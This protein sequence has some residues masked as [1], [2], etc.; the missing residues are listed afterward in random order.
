MSPITTTQVK[1]VAARP[2]QQELLDLLQRQQQMADQLVQLAQSQASLIADSHTDG[3][4]EL[5][6]RRQAIIDDFT[7]SQSQLTELTRGLDQRLELVPPADRDRIKSLIGEIGQRLA[8]ILDRD[9]QDQASLRTHRSQIK[10]ELSSMGT[11]RQ[12][13]H[14]YQGRAATNRFAD[15]RG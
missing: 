1:A 8:L 13:R 11:A 7:S 10:Q 4:L 15:R 3:L 9:E 6:T 2:W 12:A 14:A 5:L